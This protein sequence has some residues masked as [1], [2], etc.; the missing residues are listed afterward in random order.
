M[1]PAAADLARRIDDLFAQGGQADPRASREAV[2]ELLDL[3]ETGGVRAA[4]R[5]ESGWEVHPWVKRGL[6]LGF[7]WGEVRELASAGPL[8]FRDKDL[9][10]PRGLQGMPGVRLVP[11]G[12]AVR[13][14][15]YLA[16]GVVMMPPCYVNAGA[17]VGVGTMIDSH[18]LVGSCA[19]IGQGVHLSA[20]VQIGGV[21]EP[22][23]A[24]P[25]IVED[26]VFVGALAAIVEGVRVEAGAV[27][28][29]GVILTRS[30]PVFD[31]PRRQVLRAGAGAVLV[32]P[33]RSVVVPGGRALQDSWAQA[34]GLWASAALIVKERDAGTDARAALEEDL[35]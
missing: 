16:P 4:S 8:E 29:A 9:Y 14:G 1:G 5:A 32:I 34:Q 6:L 17:W 31:I 30:T 3:L 18:A 23:G 19:Q 28:G 25:V 2:N 26:Q 20:G 11:G 13:R 33:P 27:I 15:A 21:L 10:P 22:P 24:L 7:R 12:S 35:R